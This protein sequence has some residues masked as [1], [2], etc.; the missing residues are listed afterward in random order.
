[1]FGC[2]A[3]PPLHVAEKETLVGLAV[4]APFDAMFEIVT[5]ALVGVRFTSAQVP[6]LEPETSVRPSGPASSSL[7]T[8]R[9]T[10]VSASVVHSGSQRLLQ[11]VADPSPDK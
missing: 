2:T 9:P 6:P 1:Q 8:G 11:D 5:S 7:G 4:T 10:G 3:K